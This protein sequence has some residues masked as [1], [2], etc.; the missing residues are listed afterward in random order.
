ME[1][2]RLLILLVLCS[3]MVTLLSCGKEKNIVDIKP[4]PQNTTDVT[5]V[6]ALPGLSQNIGTYAITD[7][8]ENTLKTVDVLVFKVVGT[9]ETLVYRAKGREIK[10]LGIGSSQFQVTLIPHSTEK[11]RFVVIANSRAE[12]EAGLSG[13]GVGQ[14]K[15]NTLTRFLTQKSGIWNTTSNTNY[16]PLPMWGET[17]T[18]VLVNSSTAPMALNL[19]RS[20]ARVDVQVNPLLLGSFKMKSISVY[21]TNANGRIAPSASNYNALQKKVTAPSFPALLQPNSTPLVY[22]VANPLKSEQ[23]IYL[24][25]QAAAPSVNATGGISLIIGGNYNGSSTETYYKLMF[26]SNTPTPAPIPVLRNHKYVFNIKEVSGEGYA[27]KEAAIAA[28]PSNMQATITTIDMND[29][30]VVYF[31]EHYYLAMQTDLVVYPTDAFQNQTYKITTDA[32]GGWNAL[33]NRDWIL[34]SKVADGIQMIV[35]DSSL[36]GVPR[37]GTVTVTAGKIRTRIKVYQGYGSSPL[38]YIP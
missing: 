4:L 35:L 19:L 6:V 30:P 10:P 18:E 33:S 5:F 20:L 34:V 1:K 24:F 13:V 15:D 8:E 21:N 37:N 25:E 3:Y 14:T 12:V 26:L 2:I 7:N 32:P 17:T 23:E 11:Y 29:M 38:P 16:D 31:D 36:S 28:K 22:G 9:S 27:T